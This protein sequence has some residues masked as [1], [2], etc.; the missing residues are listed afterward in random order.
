MKYQTTMI[1]L[2]LALG[3]AIGMASTGHASSNCTSNS[4]KCISGGIGSSEREEMQQQASLYSLRILTAANKSGAYLS[5]IK[6]TVRDAKNH[7]LVLSAT[8][9][10]PW[11]FMALPAGRYELEANYHDQARKTGQTVKKIVDIKAAGHKQL[12][13]YFDASNVGELVY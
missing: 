8:L 9:D 4:I 10:G 6:L 11:I 12:M 1:K 2:A 5:D 3:L 7:E 13:I